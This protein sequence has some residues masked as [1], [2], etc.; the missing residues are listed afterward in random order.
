MNK[1]AD[2]SQDH[3]N[4]ILIKPGREKSLRRF[5][6][7]V[8]SGAVE[9]ESMKS[10]DLPIV[11]VRN[12]QG[13]FLGIGS[14]S[15]NSQI[16]VRIWSFDENIPIDRNFFKMRLEQAFMLRRSVGLMT[17]DGGCRLVSSESDM[18][19]GFV[20][21]KYKDFAVMQISSTGAEYFKTLVAELLVKEFGLQGVFERSD[22]S[23]RECENLPESC[24]LL[25]GKEPPELIEINENGIL[26]QVD[27]RHGHKTGFYLD[28]R[29]NRRQARELASGKRVLNCFSYTGGFGVSC[30]V[31]N[32]SEVINIDSS[33]S[34]LDM[35]DRNMALNKISPKQYKN[36]CG[37]V[38]S[39][40]RKLR[41]DKERFDLI[42]LDPPKFVDS[43]K[44]LPRA[45]RAY[46]DI[47][48]LGFQL[49]NAGGMLMSYS[50]SGLMEMPLF[51]KI[52]ADG[53]LDARADA[54]ILHI[55]G[56]DADHPT[57]LNFPEG[58]YLKGFLCLKK[59]AIR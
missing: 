39:L 35:C 16:S 28:Q 42:I 54:E 47:A 48:I 37:D 51:Q 50:C 40:L 24:G 10:V 14:Y 36:I 22:L 9:P 41:A 30:A 2:N 4:T 44:A 38:F 27:I 55:L 5:H 13:D 21:D 1:I 52:T 25:A 23:V 12:R 8:F 17:A 56:Q 33:Q 43:R 49:L 18:L 59:G 58:T 29:A 53:A 6:P 46:K 15:A 3:E 45:C 19:P 20:I 32:A 11:T 34:A 7:W 26:F 31:G 57:A